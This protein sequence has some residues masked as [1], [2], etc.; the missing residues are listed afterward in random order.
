MARDTMSVK[1]STDLGTMMASR[2]QP[3]VKFGTHLTPATRAVLADHAYQS[4]RA[5]IMDHVLGPGA[6]VSVD[7]LARE[8]NVSQTPLREA[9]AWLEAEGLLKKEALRGY[10]VSPL[11]SK[12][13]LDDL[14]E[15][16]LRL[17]PWACARAAE[18]VTAKGRL[19]LQRE[20][21]SLAVIPGGTNNERYKLLFAHDQRLH[22]LL[23]AIAGNTVVAQAYNR[24][25]CHLH[26]YRLSQRTA[27]STQTTDEH[28]RIVSAVIEGNPHEAYGAMEA[29]LGRSLRRLATG[30]E[31][32]KV[33]DS[34][35][36]NGAS[37]EV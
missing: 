32:S 34:E 27:V 14:F 36:I 9:L 12:H 21:K 30:L 5:L 37:I 11:L 4:V 18:R 19:Q 25:H 26:L 7:G 22:Q 2:S 28:R 13:E 29:H 15:F 35:A 24:A 6:H 23:F 31:T 16:R 33:L 10:F 1:T 17:E 3:T 20:S 8:L